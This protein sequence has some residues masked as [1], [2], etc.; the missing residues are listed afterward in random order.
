MEDSR[1][2]SSAAMQAFAGIIL[3][4]HRRMIPVFPARAS[5]TDSF[6]CGVGAPLLTARA[7]RWLWRRQSSPDTAWSAPAH[8]ARANRSVDESG[9][10]A[11]L[12]GAAPPTPAASVDAQTERGDLVKPRRVP[13][14]IPAIRSLQASHPRDT[15]QRHASSAEP[16][17][18]PTTNNR[19]H[20]ATRTSDSHT[21]MPVFRTRARTHI[22][23]SSSEAPASG[24][25]PGGL[26]VMRSSAIV[27]RAA[28]PVP[29]T[30][31]DVRPSATV[32]VVTSPAPP[33]PSPR[34]S[35]RA[36]SPQPTPLGPLNVPLRRVVQR[37][38]MP[39][40][41]GRD[42]VAAAPEP[43]QSRQRIVRPQPVESTPPLAWARRPKAGAFVAAADTGSALARSQMP[44]S[45]SASGPPPL[46]LQRS[47]LPP[48]R[49]EPA[50][51]SRSGGADTPPATREVPAVDDLVNRVV[52]RV[53]R[54]L[55]IEVERRGSWPWPWRS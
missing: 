15:V 38:P 9:P 1:T 53:V 55:S 8:P 18:T 49:L 24:P 10:A 36:V 35:T 41:S 2:E 25:S 11:P 7:G 16:V 27:Q 33:Q 19:E 3:S 46:V 12:P 17:R 39:A 42:R 47:P 13:G 20:T 5:R 44:V 40:A 43:R 50:S 34:I 32:R 22:P 54:Q 14:A 6:V 45:P 28:A 21:A 26:R 51:Q 52:A 48:P 31:A 23:E 37:S 30:P 4:R 29:S